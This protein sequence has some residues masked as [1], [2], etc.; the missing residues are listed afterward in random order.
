[1]PAWGT[2]AFIAAMSDRA[3]P[4]CIF[5]IHDLLDKIW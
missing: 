5:E 4:Y 2:P 3:D 1:M